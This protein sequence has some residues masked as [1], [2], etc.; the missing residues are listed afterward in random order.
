[1]MAGFELS[2][3]AGMVT[4]GWLTDRVFGG[5]GMRACFFYMAMSAISILLF[6]KCGGQSR[7]WNILFL[8]SAGFS[9]YGPQALVAIAAANLATKRAAATAGGL[10]G[11]FG[12]ASTVLSGW[13]LGALVQ[14]YDWDAGLMVIFVAALVGMA[15]FAVGWGAKADGYGDAAAAQ[16]RH[17]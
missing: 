7:I 17:P 8:C 5:R 10:T 4:C 12:Y 3:M 9:I 15:V 14:A 16:P 6:W 11:L 13:G 2:G 1:M